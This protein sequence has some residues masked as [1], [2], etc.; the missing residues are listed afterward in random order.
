MAAFGN[1]GWLVVGE[2]RE[3]RGKGRERRG[4]EGRRGGPTRGLGLRRASAAAKNE[5]EAFYPSGA[6]V[7]TDSLC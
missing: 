3:G 2:K 4:G 7:D 1:A 5:R 6:H